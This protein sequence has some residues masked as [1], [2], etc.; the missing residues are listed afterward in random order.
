MLQ[1]LRSDGMSGDAGAMA[2]LDTAEFQHGEE[3]PLPGVAK[4]EFSK[5]RT[6]PQISVNA[7]QFS[8][9]G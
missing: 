8:P 2:T 9:S 1:F 5:R 4:G 7:V 3:I 6:H